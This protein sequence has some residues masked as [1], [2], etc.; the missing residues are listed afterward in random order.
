MKALLLVAPLALLAGALA[1]ADQEPEVQVV[2]THVAGNVHVLVGRGGNIGISAGED[3][4]LMIDDQFADLEDKIR[5]AIATI[6]EGSPR[7]LVNTHWHGD[8]TGG[9]AAFSRDALILAHDNVRARLANGGGRGAPAPAEALP[10]L[11]FDDG[12]TLHFNGEKVQVRHVP[13]AHT[14]GDA[15][16]L[17]TESNV[18]HMGDL[19]FQGRFPFVDLQSGGSVRGLL[20]AVDTALAHL[21]EGCRIIPGHGELTDRAGLEEYRAM[22]AASIAL[23]EQRLAAGMDESA[24]V[25]AGPP[26]EY[27]DWGWNFVSAERWMQTVYRDLAAEGDQ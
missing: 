13:P 17:F 1:P 2:A 7:F 22:L 8:H 21:P 19:L 12:V 5:A 6:A 16:V 26:Q 27:A 20:A 9:N 18:L 11:T 24:A 4:I 25:N 14:D 15:L 10:V 3:G 23:V